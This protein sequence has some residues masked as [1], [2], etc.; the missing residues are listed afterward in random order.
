MVEPI[1]YTGS[2]RGGKNYG[3][4][5][6]E[7]LWIVSRWRMMEFLDRLDIVEASL[8]GFDAAS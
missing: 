1:G 5:N 6:V 7:I 8:D 4:L 3:V 2:E